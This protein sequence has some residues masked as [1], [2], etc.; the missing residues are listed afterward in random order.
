LVFPIADVITVSIRAAAS[1]S[2]SGLGYAYI[3]FVRNAVTVLVLLLRSASVCVHRTACR[4]GA[5][6]VLIG[7]AVRV[8]IGAAFGPEWCAFIRTF[9]LPV[10]DFIA[11]G[12]RAATGIEGPC[13]GHAYIVVIL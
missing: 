11:I 5:F 4:A 13:L 1:R 3:I 8:G 7:H 10:R 12:V 9:V 6:I 2:W